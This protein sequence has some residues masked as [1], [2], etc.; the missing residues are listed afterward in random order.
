MLVYAMPKPPPRSSS[1]SSTP[2][3]SANCA[4]RRNVRRAATWKPSVSKICEP[5][6]E[7]MPISSMAG[8]SKQAC[9][10]RKASP[11]AMENPNFWSSWA[12][13]M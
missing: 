12:V 10:A 13:A 9:S 8:S 7:W 2:V 4:C 3:R 6:W 11:A 5:M 1:P